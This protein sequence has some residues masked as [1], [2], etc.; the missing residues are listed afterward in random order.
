MLPGSFQPALVELIAPHAFLSMIFPI[1]FIAVPITNVLVLFR[2]D[3]FNPL[4]TGFAH[5][6]EMMMKVSFSLLDPP[7]DPQ[8]APCPKFRLLR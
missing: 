8:S 6:L 3:R 4:D 2:A 7:L 5:L 1:S